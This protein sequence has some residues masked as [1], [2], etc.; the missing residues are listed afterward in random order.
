MKYFILVIVVAIFIK[1]INYFRSTKR[2]K[3]RHINISEWMRMSSQNRQKLD[4][5]EKIK[6]MEHKKELLSKIRRE[7]SIY[8][9]S[10]TK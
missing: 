2:Y 10:I 6:V 9:K 5:D 8:K 7:Y 4:Q 1:A 3:R